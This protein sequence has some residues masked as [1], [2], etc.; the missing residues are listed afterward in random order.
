[1]LPWLLVRTMFAA[2]AA[3]TFVVPSLEPV[4]AQD[5]I[6]PVDLTFYA[7]PA[8]TDPAA[9]PTTLMDTCKEPAG[10]IVVTVG[11]GEAW[12][13]QAETSGGAIQPVT[14]DGIASGW[15]QIVWQL[16]DGMEVA[17]ATCDEEADGVQESQLVWAF[18]G[19]VEGNRMFLASTEPGDPLSCSIFH[20]P[21][22]GPATPVA[23]PVS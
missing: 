20:V 14:F 6:S 7:C 2:L 5:A 23:S 1:M 4:A 17:A 13:D 10:P 21:I 19:N 11:D 18:A 22:G 8:G 3:L 15:I 12:L 9:D 16:P